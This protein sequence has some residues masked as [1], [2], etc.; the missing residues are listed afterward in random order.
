MISIFSIL[1][2]FHLDQ[3]AAIRKNKLFDSLLESVFFRVGFLFIRV[4]RQEEFS[5]Q[6]SE[7]MRAC[8][9]IFWKTKKGKI[10]TFLIFQGIDFGENENRAGEENVV[11]RFK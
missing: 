8:F 7:K 3:T 5:T 9:L 11:K 6:K 10:F 2:I 4:F 1:D